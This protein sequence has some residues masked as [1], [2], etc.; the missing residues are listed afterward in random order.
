LGYT[1]KHPSPFP[2]VSLYFRSFVKKSVK[3]FVLVKKKKKKEQK[4]KGWK[5][6]FVGLL[7]AAYVLRI[8]AVE[9]GRTQPTERISG[10]ISLIFCPFCSFLLNFI[11]L[12][13][14]SPILYFRF[15]WQFN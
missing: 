6:G 13:L 5:W 10:G 3:I 8:G 12:F 1:L 4:M 9:Q 7:Y 15:I 14:G 2:C 11:S